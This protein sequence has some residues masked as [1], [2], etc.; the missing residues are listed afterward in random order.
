M[1]GLEGCLHKLFYRTLT[2][3]IVSLS[4]G[5]CL[6]AASLYGGVVHLLCTFA[7]YFEPSSGGGGYS[8][9]CLVADIGYIICQS[10]RMSVCI[11]NRTVVQRQ[12]AKAD[13]MDAVVG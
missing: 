3:D 6:A 8:L 2:P 1:F 11:W 10:L 9:T 13:V 5:V 12:A 4:C 7:V